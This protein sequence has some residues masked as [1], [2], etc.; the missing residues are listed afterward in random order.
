LIYRAVTVLTATT[1][2]VRKMKL[3]KKAVAR[4]AVL[5]AFAVASVASVPALAAST[6]VDY[7]T[8]TSQVDFGTVITGFLAIGA[9]IMFMYVAYKGITL[10]IGMLRRA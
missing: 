3:L 10:V 1:E 5:A 6:P 4:I 2:G 8:M 9:V 7:T